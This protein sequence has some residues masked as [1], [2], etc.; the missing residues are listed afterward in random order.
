MKVN[1][2]D[3]ASWKS[4]RPPTP[5]QRDTKS[6]G[7]YVIK[8]GLWLCTVITAHGAPLRDKTRGLT[9]VIVI[10]HLTA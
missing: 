9:F 1:D 8:V 7:V 4:I 5:Q 2:R 10:D 6:C 3:V